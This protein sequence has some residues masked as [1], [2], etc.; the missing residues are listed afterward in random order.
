MND[1]FFEGLNDKESLSEGM[2]KL[3]ELFYSFYSGLIRAGFTKQEALQLLQNNT[4]GNMISSMGSMAKNK[5]QI[6]GEHE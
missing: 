3:A 1:S 5:G 4:L 6:E 2:G